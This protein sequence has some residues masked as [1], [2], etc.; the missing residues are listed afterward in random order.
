LSTHLLVPLD[1]SALAEAVLP[2]AIVLARAFPA[3][4]TL[5][6]VV[7]PHAPET[8]HGDRHLTRSE[9][10]EAYLEQIVAQLAAQGVQASAL[11]R[12]GSGNVAAAIAEEAAGTHADLVVLCTHGRGGLRDALFGSVAQ[13]VLQHGTTPVFLLKPDGPSDFVCRTIMVPLDGSDAAAGALPSAAAIARACGAAL[14]LVSVVPTPETAPPERAAATRLMPSAAAEVLDLEAAQMQE[15]L[16][17]L[18]STL[19][20]GGITASGVVERG[21]AV[22]ML[23]DAAKVSQADLIVMATHGRSGLAGTWAGSV[24]SRVIG[25]TAIAVLLVRIP[26]S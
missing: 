7:E 22:R 26:P 15:Y 6:H 21:E 12:P 11:V 13:Q 17:G 24:A 4:V 1:G 19:A 16:I 8:V 9:D 14:R 18:T 23:L 3:R 25:H 2:S 10:A 5:L 20:A